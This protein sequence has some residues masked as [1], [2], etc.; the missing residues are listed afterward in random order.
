MKIQNDAINPRKY[1]DHL[2]RIE[3]EGEIT[4]AGN[5]RKIA[6]SKTEDVCNIFTFQ[7]NTLI[8]VIQSQKRLIEYNSYY[9]AF[10]L[11]QLSEEEFEKISDKFTYKPK[12]ILAQQLKAKIHCLKNLTQINFTPCELAEIFQCASSSVTNILT[13]Q[14]S[15]N[16]IS[17]K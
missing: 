17:T 12:K 4:I 5:F 2:L 11:G 1:S 7:I 14:K 3:S 6:I 13:S 9:N 8:E 16:V 10:L 15:N